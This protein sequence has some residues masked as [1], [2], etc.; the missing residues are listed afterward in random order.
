MKCQAG[1][2]YTGEGVQSKEATV[3]YRLDGKMPASELAR[4][5]VLNTVSKQPAMI[6]ARVAT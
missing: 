1:R 4:Q 3:Q 5:L 6:H 2:G